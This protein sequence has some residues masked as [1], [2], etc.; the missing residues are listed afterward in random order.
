MRIVEVGR[1]VVTSGRVYAG[2]ALIKPSG[3]TFSQRVPAG[4]YPV[5]L[6][7]ATLE[8]R[9]QRVAFARLQLGPGQPVRWAMATS[10][11]QNLATLAEDEFFGYPVDSGT[12]S[13]MDGDVAHQL[14]AMSSAEAAAFNERVVDEFLSHA[15]NTWH[16]ADV[17]VNAS[18]GA[19]L[20]GF[21]SGWGDGR[22]ASYW[23]YD[24]QDQVVCL[25]TDFSLFGEDDD[26]N[27]E[28]DDEDGE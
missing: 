11:D 13:F 24:D 26:E 4:T 22:Y 9:D 1:L 8:N 5:L 23:G 25:V 14:G 19:N 15:V 10:D 6:S 27:G 18:N 7:V 2:D 17:T 3:L 20:V 16:W 28:D 12:G 21:A